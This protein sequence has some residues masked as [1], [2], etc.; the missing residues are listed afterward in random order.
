MIKDQLIK[1]NVNIA[2]IKYW[3]AK[4]YDVSHFKA[5]GKTRPIPPVSILVMPEDLTKW[6]KVE[7]ICDSCGKEFYGKKAGNIS[8]CSECFKRPKRS[9]YKPK[10]NRKP[11]PEDFIQDA[12]SLTKREITKKYNVSYQTCD[13]WLKECNIEIISHNDRYG[14]NAYID[15]TEDIKNLLLKG[16]AL[17][18]IS[19]KLDITRPIIKELLKRIDMPYQTWFDRKKHEYDYI[20]GNFQHFV[21]LNKAKTLKDISIDEGVSV[22]HLKKAFK[23]TNT[24]ICIHSYNKSK[25]ELEVR[26]Y[27]RSLGFE[28]FSKKYGNVFEIDCL[29][30]QNNFGIE[31]CG[32]YWHSE[33][34]QRH[35]EKRLLSLDKGIKLFT[36]FEN[37]WR[38]K[39]SIAKSMINHR[40]GLSNKIYARKCII[41]EISNSEARSF[42]ENN[43]ISGYS[44]SSIN[45][46]L[47]YNDIIMSVISLG[48]PRFSKECEYEIIRFSSLLNYTIVGGLSKLWKHF[49]EKYKPKSVLTYSDLRFGEGKGYMSC[50]FQ[51]ISKT[52]P[53]YFYFNKK[54]GTLESRHKYQ[55]HKL[56]NMPCYNEADTEKAIMFNNG[57]LRVYDCGSNKYIWKA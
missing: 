56:K 6:H 57:F 32:E 45:I 38:F 14:T 42:H 4:G 48:K 49:V 9:K 8:T 13:R 10:V 46:A 28:C 36:L 5:D 41:R 25:G 52:P 50:G 16:Y 55:K 20:I 23:E 40:L 53:N 12:K 7:C 27:I 29:V 43:H 11:V 18:E 22:E 24:D 44:K 17:G 26:D 35:E 3:K 19:N 21:N 37:E 51:W 1:V 54:L 2:N 30:P 31:Y 33:N 34:K 15:K 47:I 39:T